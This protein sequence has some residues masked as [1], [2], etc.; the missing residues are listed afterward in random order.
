VTP[1]SLAG[2][3]VLVTGASSGIGLAT[4]EALA[5]AGATVLMVCR[6]AGRGQAARRRVAQRSGNPAAVELLLAD[7]SSQAQVR[8]LAAELE[9]RPQPLHVLVNNAGVLEERRRLGPDG[10]E[11]TWATN[12]LAYFLLTEL[13]LDRLRASAPARIV[14]VASE[15][16]G[17]LDLEDVQYERRPYR[18]SAAYA[19]SKQ[20]DRMLTWDTARR[21]EKDGGVTANAMHPGGVNTPLL[22]KAS[23]LQGAAAEDWARRIGRT[24][25][26]GA[27]TVVWLASS[28]EVSGLSG[29]FWI[30]RREVACRF[31]D[32]VQEQ[33]LR[34][35]CESMT[36]A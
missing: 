33:R 6:D 20:A 22:A 14:N 2:R 24:P 10:I 32:D 31:R 5:G 35:L 11:L 12:V 18:G 15:L 1:P 26:Q 25:E 36:A 19:Q 4:A 17:G 30:D 3:S 27:D 16:A 7:L 28:P 29:R 34:A 9:R 13:L 8:G 21:L 23:G